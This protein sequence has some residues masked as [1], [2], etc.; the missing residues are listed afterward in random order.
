MSCL[1]RQLLWATI[2]ASRRRSARWAARGTANAGDAM[3]ATMRRLP[4]VLR[5]SL[6]TLCVVP[7]N[8]CES[9]FTISSAQVAINPARVAISPVIPPVS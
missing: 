7:S 2:D 5:R 6:W 3:A 9:P 8:L 1:E 4:S